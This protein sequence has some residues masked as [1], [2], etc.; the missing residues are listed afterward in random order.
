[1]PGRATFP[2]INKSRTSLRT[3]F[4]IGLNLMNTFHISPESITPM[5]ILT[6]GQSGCSRSLTASIRSAMR[7]ASISFALVTLS[8]IMSASL[9]AFAEVKTGQVEI[10]PFVGYHMFESYQ[11]LGDSVTYGVRLGYSFTSNWA[12]EGAVR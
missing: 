11:N 12:I 9:P 10:S 4:L 8:A 1:G 2:A 5:D 6:A 3:W 7:P